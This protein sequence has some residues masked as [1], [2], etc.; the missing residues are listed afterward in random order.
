MRLDSESKI[1]YSTIHS[2]LQYSHENVTEVLNFF[3]QAVS[4]VIAVYI[5]YH[6]VY[7]RE[8]YS[9]ATVHGRSALPIPI[10]KYFKL[11]GELG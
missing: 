9:I 5:L 10:V 7:G 2:S 11:Q 8:I 3:I 4:Y 6:C 1:L